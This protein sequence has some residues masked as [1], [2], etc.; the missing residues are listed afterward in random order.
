MDT[1]VFSLDGN[2]HFKNAICQQLGYEAG[3]ITFHQF[4]DEETLVKIDTELANKSAIFI[5][6]LDRPDVKIASLIFAVETARELGAN[7]VGLIAPYLAYMRQDKRF[8]PGEGISSTYFAKLLSTYVDWLIT[9]DPHLHRRHSL[10][11]IFTIPSKVLHAAPAIAQW[12]KSN[13]TQ[14]VL[15]GPDKE[16]EQWVA[17]IANAI[18]APF[19]IVEKQRFSDTDV[20]ATVPQLANYA[21]HTPVVVDDIISTAAT[22]IETVRHITS[23]ATKP[24]YCVGVHAVFSGDAY[25]NLLAAGTA[26]VATC[27]TIAH[28]SN[29]I[30]LSNL[31]VCEGEKYFT[32][33]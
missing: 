10:D 21:D 11:E 3:E 15:I 20:K 2:N 16:S 12:I 9:V 27:N 5:L 29:K 26:G 1:V 24:V 30:D 31:I 32:P 33:A 13:V 28:P 14:P 19:L 6:S 25:Q 23:L 18:Q 17:E 8:H 7:K 4:P 22:M